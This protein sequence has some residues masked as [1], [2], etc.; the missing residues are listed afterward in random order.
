MLKKKKETK[1]EEIE[2]IAKEATKKVKRKYRSRHSI[3]IRLSAIVL[4]LAM[5]IP[6]TMTVI[7]YIQAL[8]EK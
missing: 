7:I 8:L 3:W 6:V 1:E 2:K 4:I 5:V